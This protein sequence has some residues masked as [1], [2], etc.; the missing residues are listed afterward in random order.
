MQMNKKAPVLP[1]SHFFPVHLVQAE[2][3]GQAVLNCFLPWHRF[4]LGKPEYHYSRAIGETDA[5]KV[6]HSRNM[7]LQKEACMAF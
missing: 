4:L 7:L 2:E 6:S 5:K 3:E 1:S